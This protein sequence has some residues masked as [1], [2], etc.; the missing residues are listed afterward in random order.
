MANLRELTFI[1]EGTEVVQL[2]KSSHERLWSWWIHVIK[3]DQVVDAEFL[4]VEDNV[5]KIRS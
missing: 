3:M 5:A 2:L 1:V 4:Q